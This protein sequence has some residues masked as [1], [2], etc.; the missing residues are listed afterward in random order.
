MNQ[1]ERIT[2]TEKP[3]TTEN[4]LVEK[5]SSEIDDPQIKQLL[6]ENP[7]QLSKVLTIASRIQHYQGPVPPPDILKGYEEILPG[8]AERMLSMAEKEQN[9]R[10]QIDTTETTIEKSFHRDEAK[11]D[12][13]GQYIAAF[14]A[15]FSL[16]I[17]TYLSLQGHSVIA[18]VIG[19]TTVI[20]LVSAFV[21]GRVWNNQI[22]EE[23]S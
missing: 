1:K 17:S 12:A 20:G 10:H 3:S 18:G 8:A 11:R 4:D 21:V 13:R 16:S 5:L 7:A 22:T 14:L 19:G 2:D 15:V 6:E 23:T 9:H